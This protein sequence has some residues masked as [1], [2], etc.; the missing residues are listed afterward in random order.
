MEAFSFVLIL[1]GVNVNAMLVSL[2]RGQ[3]TFSLSLVGIRLVVHYM[4]TPDTLIS[5]FFFCHQLASLK[6]TPPAVEP[7]V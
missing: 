3:N 2:H 4:R 6:L 7:R 5:D 1:S